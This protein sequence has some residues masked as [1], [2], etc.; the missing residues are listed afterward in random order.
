[1]ENIIPLGILLGVIACGITI[2][3]DLKKPLLLTSDDYSQDNDF[4]SQYP[5]TNDDSEISII[6]SGYIL[7]AFAEYDPNYSPWIGK[8]DK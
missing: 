4:K 5:S 6:E 3:L 7:G 2:Y 1:M 8:N